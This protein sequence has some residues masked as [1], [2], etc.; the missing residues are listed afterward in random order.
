MNCSANPSIVQ[1][2]RDSA[3]G[4]GFS[5]GTH[6]NNSQDAARDVYD[7]LQKFFRLNPE[8]VKNK[9]VLSGGSY[10]GVYVPNIATVIHQQNLAIAEGNGIPGAVH[11]NLEAT[12]ISNPV[13][14]RLNHW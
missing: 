7:F 1:T 8:L 13:T 4:V 14:V 10:G 9:L 12:L 6:I 3:V 11:L 5:Y 2:F